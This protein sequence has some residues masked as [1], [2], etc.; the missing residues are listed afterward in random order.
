MLGALF[1]E[2][3]CNATGRQKNENREESRQGHFE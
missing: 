3:G 2:S 1:D